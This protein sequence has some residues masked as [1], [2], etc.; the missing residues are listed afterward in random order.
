ML[1]YASDALMLQE[2]HVG[3]VYDV[4]ESNHRD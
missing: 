3:L 1:Y 4:I 2:K